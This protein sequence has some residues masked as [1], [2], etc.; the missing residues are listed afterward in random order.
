MN[1]PPDPS[2]RSKSPS[3]GTPAD[4]TAA[5]TAIA[6]SVSG[7]D[8][9]ANAAD[10]PTP[11]AKLWFA[12]QF[13][14]SLALVGAIVAILAFAPERL[15]GEHDASAGTV[16]TPVTAVRDVD[17]EHLWI[18]PDSAFAGKLAVSTTSKST[19]RAPLLIVPGTVA[20][21]LRPVGPDNAEQWQFNEPE[22]LEAYF[23]WRRAKIDEQF[24]IEQTD[25]VRELVDTQVGSRRTIVE[26]LRRLV[27]AGTDSQ[28]DLQLAEAELLEAEIEGRQQI[29][30]IASDLR[31]ARQDL[32][33]A[34]RQIAMLG[35]D[36]ELLDNATLDVDV[37]VA[38]VAEEYRDRV[39]IGQ[40]C[41]A[42]FVGIRGRVFPGTVQ[43]ISP[44]LSAERRALR[45]LFF[46]D[47][48]DDD[49]RPGMFAT[50][51]LG[52]DA[53]ESILIPADSVIHIGRDDYVFVRGTDVAA[54]QWRL[55]QVVVG[56]QSG[57]MIEIIEGLEEGT[58]LISQGAILLKPIA[59]SMLRQRERAS[60]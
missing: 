46:V 28:A 53:R 37:V 9:P 34:S 39:R 7:D 8:S 15:L 32:A 38:E 4:E 43:L 51:G 23:D 54:Q 59:A 48:P 52:T 20:A 14:G 19:V 27:A 5:A 49:L 18:D 35:L 50:I 26:R 31:R 41:E 29:H 3:S 60:S 33:V 10:A 1:S 57:R 40:S 45:I 2:N 47:D 30:E 44:T 24:S 11:L 58:E 6:A 25:R 55:V 21:S 16:T 56:D 12:V 36:V 22:A 13:F 17:G 42:R